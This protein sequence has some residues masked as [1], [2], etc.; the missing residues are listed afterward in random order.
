MR[1]LQPQG[2]PAAVSLPGLRI[3]HPSLSWKDDDVPDTANDLSSHRNLTMYE[4]KEIGISHEGGF[5]LEATRRMRKI[6]NKL[7]TECL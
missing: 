3:S 4:K 6:N 1:Q 5:D 7:L 2:K